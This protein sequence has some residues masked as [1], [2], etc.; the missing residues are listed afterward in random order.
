MGVKKTSDEDKA[1][2]SH[3]KKEDEKARKHH[4][5]PDCLSECLNA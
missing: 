4:R 1:T 2:P 5:N 3:E